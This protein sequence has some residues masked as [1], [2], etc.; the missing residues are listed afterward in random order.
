MHVKICGLKTKEAVDTAV[1]FGATHL[2]FI[3]SASKRQISPEMIRQI[4][5]DVPSNV[6]KVGVFVNEN[7]DFV[8]NAVQIAQLDIVQL[9][10]NE[11]QA[12][13]E[14]LDFPVIKAISDIEQAKNYRNVILLFDSP[15]GGSGQKFDWK[16]DLSNLTAPYFIA[17][18][19][20]PENI[21]E[22]VKT[23]PSAYGFDVSSGVETNGVKDLKKIKEFIKNVQQ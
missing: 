1:K 13:I 17:G 12:Y 15:T 5:R 2:G 22:A 14:A 23:F 19:L 8:K 9:H 20:N 7:L 11:N 6:K 10:G 3:L 21:S 16:T 4:T 18:G